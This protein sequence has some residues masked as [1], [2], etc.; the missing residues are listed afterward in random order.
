MVNET[1]ARRFW[2]GQDPLGKRLSVSGPQGKLLEV[3]GVTRDGKYNTLGE[4]A[5]PFFYLMHGHR[6]V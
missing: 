5:T 2:P 4:A 3:V 6:A 1:F